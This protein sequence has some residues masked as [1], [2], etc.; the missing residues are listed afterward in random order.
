MKN[1]AAW[2]PQALLFPRPSATPKLAGRLSGAV[3]KGTDLLLVALQAG[4]DLL[5]PPHCEVCER[6]LVIGDEAPGTAGCLQRVLCRSCAEKI[7]WSGEN[8]CPRCGHVRPLEK[9][10]VSPGN[11]PSCTDWPA[12]APQRTAAAAVYEAPW[13]DLILALKFGRAEQLVPLFGLLLAERIRATGLDQGA[14]VLVPVPLRRTVFAERG[15]NQAEVIAVVAGKRL[16]L[17][18]APKFLRK[19]R[20]TRPQA[21]LSAKERRENLRGAFAVS[22]KAARRWAGKCVI[23]VDDVLTT[24]ATAWECT[25]TLQGRGA[26]RGGGKR[27]K[28]SPPAAGEVRIAVLARSIIE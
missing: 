11:C 6:P 12:G 28:P 19:V 5:Y 2:N 13:R 23:L 21:L 20:H 3:R 9:W 26:T 22:A 14:A 4:A 25:R 27:G 24:G 16:G 8:D 18:V 10:A 15:F 17:P 7:R 1:P